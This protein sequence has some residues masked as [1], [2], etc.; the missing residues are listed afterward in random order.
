MATTRVSSGPIANDLASA[1]DSAVLMERCGLR[2]DSWQAQVLRSHARRILLLCSRQSGKSTV[3]AVAALHAALYD[4]PALMLLLSPSLRQSQELFKIVASLYT[5]L[6]KPVPA[7]QESALRL[8]LTNGSRIVSLPGTEGTVRGYSGVRLLIVDEASRV[9]DAFY[10]AVRPMLAVSGGRMICLST[11]F[12]KRGFFYDEW[13]KGQQWER[14]KITATD[15]PRITPEFLAEERASL[16]DWWF[17]QE[18]L[19]EFV[20]AVDQVFA[21]DLVIRALSAE[22]RPLWKDT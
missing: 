6:G 16:G 14:V 7:E 20:E 21:H 17:R 2:P 12:G 4:P 9:D 3:A 10:F 13:T 8:E 18:Y 19:C 11:P 5:R 1:L 15:C 22:V